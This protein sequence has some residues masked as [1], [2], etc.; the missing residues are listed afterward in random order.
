MSLRGLV[1]D[2][3]FEGRVSCETRHSVLKAYCAYSAIINHVFVFLYVKS[4]TA[5]IWMMQSGYFHPA[6]A[7]KQK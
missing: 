7:P 6:P 5:S 4:E 3:Y 1:I 2:T